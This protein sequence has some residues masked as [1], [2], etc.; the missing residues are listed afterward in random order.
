LICITSVL[1]LEPKNP[2]TSYNLARGY[3]LEGDNMKAKNFYYRYLY[4]VPDAPDKQEVLKMI[5]DL[6]PNESVD[7]MFG[8]LNEMK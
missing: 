3:V 4:L 8:K 7:K 5:D 1:T 2:K 6:N